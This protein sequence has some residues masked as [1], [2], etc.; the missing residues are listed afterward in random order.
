MQKLR[1]FRLGLNTVKALA[2]MLVCF[3]IVAANLA[4]GRPTEQ[5]S[6][7]IKYGYTASS[8][9]AVDGCDKT[10][11]LERCCTHTLDEAQPWWGVDLEATYDVVMV[12]VVNR[13]DCCGKS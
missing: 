10:D 13:G 8:E 7:R 2:S 11:F 4:I 12:K 1:L 3:F 6:T 5:S 9:M